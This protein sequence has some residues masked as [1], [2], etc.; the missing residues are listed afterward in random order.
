M[1]KSRTKV[2]DSEVPKRRK[3]I[4]DTD[5]SRR[6]H[7]IYL[8][9]LKSDIAGDEASDWYQAEQELKAGK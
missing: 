2:E 8:E 5:I 7:K 1:S 4:T 9:R 3:K 6:A